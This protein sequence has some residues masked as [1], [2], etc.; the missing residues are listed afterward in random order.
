M[1][2]VALILALAVSLTLPQV[3]KA[4]EEPASEA[5]K[6]HQLS[7]WESAR[8][9]KPSPVSQLAYADDLRDAGRLIQ[10]S[11]QYRAIT[12]AWPQSPEAAK[13]QY[14]YAQLLERRGKPTDAF[15]EYQYLLEAYAGF[16]PYEEVLERQYGIADRIATQPRHF[17]IFSYDAAEEAIPLFEKMIQN[18][19]QWKRSVEL[20]FRIARIYEKNGQYDL[21]LDAYSLY[22]Q[23]YP[24]SRLTESAAYGHGKCAY[25]YARENPN[26][27]DLRQSAEAV[28]LSFLERYPRSEMAGLTRTYLRELQMAQA[29]TLYQQA[30]IYDRFSREVSDQKQ[31]RLLMTAARLCY[32]R[33]I[34]EYPL[35]RWAETAR[36]RISQV[37]QHMEQSRDN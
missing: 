37:D 19:P 31:L 4:I 36:A 27:I 18:A 35:S 5:K 28:L 33:V 8:P 2:W 24:V 13:A 1:G 20:Q 10:A 25:E 15:N 21:A 9:S 32:Q 22:Q 17:L 34:D 14:H 16:V 6:K 23:K 30:Q 29:S 7:W 11:R 12:Y 26:A 3:V